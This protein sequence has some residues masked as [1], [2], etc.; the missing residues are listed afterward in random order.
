MDADAVKKTREHYNS[1][2]N[3][4]VSRDQVNTCL[5]IH[6]ANFL[7]CCASVHSKQSLCFT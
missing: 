2:A 3:V 7:G 6:V 4:Y 1:H 5:S